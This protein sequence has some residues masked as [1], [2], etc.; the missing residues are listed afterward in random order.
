MNIVNDTTQRMQKTVSALVDKLSKIRSGRAHAGLFDNIVVSCYGSDMALSHVATV[1]ITDARTLSVSV[2]DKQNI[3]A[4]E[5][6]I[7]DSNLGVNPVAAGQTLRVALPLLSEERR[8]D[9]T[10]IVGKEAEEA[11]VSV[12]NIRRDGITEVKSAVKDKS[13][14]EDEGKRLEQEIQKITD[15]VIKQINDISAEKQKELMTV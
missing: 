10:K 13:L 6:A 9:L 15:D 2:W 4:V 14:S 8:H 5:K 7:R 1:S 12:R 3:T 11:R